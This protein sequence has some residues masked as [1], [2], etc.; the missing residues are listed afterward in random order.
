MD[1]ANTPARG[2][3][4]AVGFVELPSSTPSG[5]LLGRWIPPRD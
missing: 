5:P 1:P 3:Y 4:Q 2:F